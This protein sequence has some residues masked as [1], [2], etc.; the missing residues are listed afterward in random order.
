MM[1]IVLKITTSLP[2]CILAGTVSFLYFSLSNL[3]IL[4]FF[5]PHLSFFIIFLYN[6]PSNKIPYTQGHTVLTFLRQRNYFIILQLNSRQVI[7]QNQDVDYLP[8]YHR[9]VLSLLV[10]K[11]LASHWNLLSWTLTASIFLSIFIFQ[12]FTRM[13]L[14]ACLQWWTTFLVQIFKPFLIP[15]KIK[16]NFFTESTTLR[17]NLYI[18]YF[19]VAVRIYHEKRWLKEV[20][21]KGVF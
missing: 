17:A 7:R 5:M 15:L 1:L 6:H 9:T 14:K 13:A 10:N 11:V 21:R 4:Y 8:K 20:K 18:S 19:F 12:A 16:T 3:Y 2:A